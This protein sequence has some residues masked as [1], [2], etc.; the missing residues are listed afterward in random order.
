MYSIYILTFFVSYIGESDHS[1]H[2]SYASNII[3]VLQDCWQKN[4]SLKF[5]FFSILSKSH[6]KIFPLLQ[7]PLFYLLERILFPWKDPIL[8]GEQPNI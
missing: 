5:Y 7:G 8:F 4:Y 2:N 6:A 1:S 3:I